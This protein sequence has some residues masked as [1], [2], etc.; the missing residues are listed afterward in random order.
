MRQFSFIAFGAL[1]LLALSF[2]PAEAA[3][4]KKIRYCQ[5]GRFKPCVCWQDVHKDVS[6]RPKYPACGGNAAVLTR[7]K[8][9]GIF[10]VVVRD[11][12]NRDRWPESGFNGCSIDTAQSVSP[13]ASCSAFK[14][15]KILYED[16]KGQIQ[17]VNCLGA[18][19]TSKLFKSVVRM[20]AKI[21]DAP[22]TTNDPLARWCL[23]SP[24]LPLN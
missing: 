17:R 19:G 24:T 2:V 6:Y 1:V 20:T 4:K 13:P 3:T 16:K 7:G 21:S 18:P 12:Q 8:Y 22:G 11:N 5:G 23:R 14:V 9:K 10:S 15:Q